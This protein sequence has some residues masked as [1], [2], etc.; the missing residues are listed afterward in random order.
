MT[1][2]PVLQSFRPENIFA[3]P[4]YWIGYQNKLL[5]QFIHRLLR[6]ELRSILAMTTRVSG[7][8]KTQKNR[9]HLKAVF[10]A[11]D[12][13]PFKQCKISS[14]VALAS[15]KHITLLSRK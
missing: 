3:L 10:Y 2:T 8:L 6:I 1:I 9:F 7:S 12:D 15:P 13:Y 14:T 4:L 11:L 5:T